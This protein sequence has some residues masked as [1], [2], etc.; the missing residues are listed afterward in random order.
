MFLFWP[1]AFFNDLRTC[2]FSSATEQSTASRLLKRHRRRRKQRPPRLERV[3]TVELSLALTFYL[4][5]CEIALCFSLLLQ[6]FIRWTAAELVCSERVFV[7][8]SHG[9]FVFFNSRP[10]PSAAWQTPQCPW[11]SSPSHSTWVCTLTHSR[12]WTSVL[13][14]EISATAWTCR[15]D[16]LTLF[17]FLNNAEKYNFLGISIVGQSNERGDGG[18]YIGSI[19]KGGAVA[20]DGRIEPGDM[21]LQVRKNN[22]YFCLFR[23]RF[24]WLFSRLNWLIPCCVKCPSTFSK[25][26]ADVIRSFV[27]PRQP[28]ET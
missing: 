18:I 28:S 26:Q 19:M 16:V 7:S 11:T 17:W 20:A 2:R 9:S 4:C 14:L 12:L 27:L 24:C 13:N 1:F 21:L 22:V 6:E 23:W 25:A 8:K 10:P 15:S 3:C 5:V